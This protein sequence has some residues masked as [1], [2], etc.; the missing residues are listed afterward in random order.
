[1]A[2]SPLCFLRARSNELLVIGIDLGR[3]HSR[4]GIYR[5]NAFELI[6]DA[7]GRSAI[8][9]YVAF[10]DSGPLVGFEAQEQALTNLKN[11]I[12]DIR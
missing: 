1:M 3:T 9:S 12:F 2:S 10:T 5:N 11:T 7:Q 8:P 4:V 6:H